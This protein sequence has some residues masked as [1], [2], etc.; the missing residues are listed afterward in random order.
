[1]SPASYRTAPPRVGSLHYT[2][3]LYTDFTTSTPIGTPIDRFNELFKI[4]APSPAPAL[5]RANYISGDGATAKLSFGSSQPVADYTSSAT[6]AGFS[7]V[8]INGSYSPSES[9]NNFRIGVLDGSEHVT[10]TL[11]FTVGPNSSNG[12]LA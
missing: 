11:N 7:A 2:D 4:L 8:D 6:A 5:S 1:M 12:N 9:G 10:G 3:G